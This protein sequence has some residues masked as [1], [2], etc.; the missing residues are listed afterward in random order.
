MWNMTA[1]EPD[2]LGKVGYNAYGEVRGWTAYNGEPMPPWGELSG[3]IQ[4]GWA[5]AAVAIVAAAKANDR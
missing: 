4:Q 1:L 3:A 2:D 5:E